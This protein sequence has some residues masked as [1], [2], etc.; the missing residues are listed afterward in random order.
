MTLHAHLAALL[1]KGTLL[2]HRPTVAELQQHL[3]NAQDLLKD[4]R[5]AS[6]SALGRFNAAY[7]ASHALLTAAIKLHGF[8][9]GSGPGHRQVLFQLLDQLLP[10]AASAKS[11][12]S[13]AHLT[14]NR[15][16]YDG[17]PVNATAA[18][19]GSMVAAVENLDEEVRLALKAL[20]KR[21][22]TQ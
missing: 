22:G 20:V 15:A 2:E 6:V 11:V 8:R 14:R 13:Q 9:P 1:G 5:N 4:A 17:E 7:G 16:E 19:V 12:L 21:G 10:A 18:L 3:A